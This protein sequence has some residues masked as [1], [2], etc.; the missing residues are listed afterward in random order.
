[1]RVAIYARV[2]TQRQAIA[3][4]IDQQLER[5][6]GYVKEQGWELLEENIFRDD[7]FSGS[8]LERP[9]LDRLRDRVAVGELDQVILTAPDRL[10]RNYVHQMVLLEELEK[11]GCQ[12]LFLDR[13][14][15]Q[16]PHDQLVLQIRGAVA[17]YERVLIAERMRRGRQSKYR[18]GTLLPWSTPPYGY[19]VDPD[20]PRDPGGVQIDESQAVV[21]REIYAFYLQSDIS[22]YGLVNHLHEMGV[23]APQ[24]DVYWNSAT[25]RGVL[26][27]PA[28]TGQIYVGRTRPVKPLIRRSATHPIGK[29]AQSRGHL[30]EEDWIL[31]ANISAIVSQEQFDQV[32]AKLSLNQKFSRRNNTTHQYLLRALVSCGACLLGC[33][34]RQVNP[35]YCYYLC[36]GRD[37]QVYHHLDHP[38]SARYI[39]AKQLDELVW[40][41]LC[42]VITHPEIITAALHRAQGG[43]W[44]P[45]ELQAR[46]EN[47]RKGQKTLQNQLER[48]TEAYL[49]GIIPLAE[50]QRRRSELE[51]RSQ[52]LEEQEKQLNNQADRQA[53]LGGWSTSTEMFCKRIQAGLENATFE[54]KRK[55]VELLIDRVVV[56]NGDVEIRYVIPTSPESEH[57]RFCHLRKDYFNQPF[58]P[59]SQDR[60]FQSQF[61]GQRIGHIGAPSKRFLERG[62]SYFLTSDSSHLVTNAHNLLFGSIRTASTAS[63]VSGLTFLLTFKGVAQQSFHVMRFQDGLSGFRQFGLVLNL[64]FA[65]SR[66]RGQAQKFFSCPFQTAFQ[67]FPQRSPIAFRSHHQDPFRPRLDFTADF[68]LDQTFKR[69]PFGQQFAFTLLILYG[70]R[71]HLLLPVIGGLNPPHH[72]L[73]CFSGLG[74]WTQVVLPALM[75]V[76]PDRQRTHLAVPNEQKPYSVDDLKHPVHR[77]NIQRIICRVSGY[78]LRHQRQPQWVKCCH[79]HLHLCQTGVIFAVSELKQRVFPTDMVARNRGRIQSHPFCLQFIHPHYA[80]AQIGFDRLPRLWLTQPPKQERQPVIGKIQFF[81]L[82]S[83]DPLN[84]CLRLSHPDLYWLFT[85]VA[86]RE[87]MCQPDRTDPAP[88][89]ALLQSVSLQ[90]VIKDARQTQPLHNFQQKRKVIDPF[91]SNVH[92]RGHPLSLSNNSRFSQNFQRMVSNYGPLGYLDVFDRWG[93]GIGVI[94][95]LKFPE[96]RTF[97]LN[98][99]KQCPSGQWFSVQSLIGYLKAN[100]PYFLIPQF[101]PKSDRWGHPVGRYDNFHEGNSSE[102]REKTVSPDDPDAFERVEGRYIERFLEYIPL[103][104]RFVDLAYT[105]QE[106]SGLLPTRGML[107]AF[108]INER[109]L[110]MFQN[111]EAQPRVTVQ[112][113]FDVIIESDFYPA[114]LIQKVAALGEQASNPAGGHG[115]YVGIFL[116][117][118]ASVASALIQQPEL[119]IIDFL[120]KMTGRDLPQNVQIELDEWAGHA[121]QFV[122][123]EN[124]ALLETVNL[125][126]EAERFIVEKISPTVSLVH[127]PGKVFAILEKLE[128]VP[129]RMKHL[130]LEFALLEETT[131]SIF[132]KEPALNNMPKPARQVKVSRSVTINY[133]FPDQESFVATQKMLG[134]LRCPF[135]SDP[136]AN[137][138]TIQQKEQARFDEALG[139]LV[140]DFLIEVE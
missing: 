58:F 80:S 35:G 113:N 30:P 27:N 51:R 1:M 56:T 102:S 95:T 36:S 42:E 138:I 72:F 87:N 20:R 21:V 54:Q 41:D 92:L 3:Q 8:G 84:C 100:Y 119:N 73:T 115:A 134:E 104:M 6:Q 25:L 24:G 97:L 11:Q 26:T 45:Q 108:R 94:P 135:Q 77:W 69:I 131:A 76:R 2:S 65:T 17:E 111:E 40:K 37:S 105:S 44:L 18:A 19:Q 99:L 71:F 50:Y 38:C 60:L 52:G 110:R 125:P 136:K 133:Q 123:Y 79:H 128:Q 10:A 117:K 70:H 126:V 85:R 109:F 129:L 112:P 47:L 75:D 66:C 46:Q 101:F 98:V 67:T 107:K 90:M 48:L 122:L 88:T 53:E 22:L 34:G 116:L 49:N 78:H 130:P 89:Q 106:Y 14:M 124:F 132:P 13:P 114:R 29:P 9:G 61:I 118:K 140:N 81:Y 63:Q 103:I 57:V 33:T 68:G 127:S 93:S 31:V 62:D 83:R 120:K 39:P 32:K 12:V 59:V 55:L 64:A 74:Q 91:G 137:I 96:I 16:D 82:H 23:P 5:L 139:K 28:Y 7:G 43:D 86:L 121:D 4:T 15:S